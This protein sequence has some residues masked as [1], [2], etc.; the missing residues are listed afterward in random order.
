MFY[1]LISRSERPGSSFLVLS[2]A[3]LFW[4][5]F[6]LSCMEE[7]LLKC[8]VFC[9]FQTNRL[10]SAKHDPAPEEGSF[11][12]SGVQIGRLFRAPFPG[13]KGTNLKKKKT[14]LRSFEN[15]FTYHFKDNIKKQEFHARFL[16]YMRTVKL[17]DLVRSLQFSQT[18][19]SFG[20]CLSP[21]SSP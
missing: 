19:G 3:I 21:C 6:F 15:R 11:L 8:C 2:S 14:L 9:F 12:A 18:F 5:C 1:L 7:R 13:L 16:S 17:N 10:T 4:K 20:F